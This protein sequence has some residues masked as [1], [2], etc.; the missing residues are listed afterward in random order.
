MTTDFLPLMPED[1]VLSPLLD[2]ASVLIKDSQS[3]VSSGNSVGQ[4]LMPLL[5]SM[6]S[7][8]TNKIE[9]QHT[10][11]ADIEQA[12]KKNFNA[13]EKLARRQRLAIAHMQAESILEDKAHK[14]LYHAEWVST[15]HQTLYE[16]LPEQ[17][18][19]TEEGEII[20]P[21]AFR[22]RDVQA[23]QHIAPQHQQVPAYFAAW[24]T[25]YNRQ[26]G[27]ERRV[28]AAICA[29]HR[30]AWIHPFIDGN[31]RTARLHTH[32]AFDNLDLTGGLWSP[33]RGLARTHEQY[34]ARLQ[35]A[36]MPKRNDLDGRGNLSQ[37][38]LVNFVD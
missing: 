22:T 34:Y 11:P 16:L 5:R 1:R 32:L 4:C 10:K 21:G 19:V 14:D 18:R 30:L 38:E 28:I 26:A 9:G 25:A 27:N 13:D 33:M 17:D 12:L 31:G 7:Y 35:N 8:Y 6:N 24:N 20:I 2:K 36:D 37:E 23:G 29:H 3:L 15:I